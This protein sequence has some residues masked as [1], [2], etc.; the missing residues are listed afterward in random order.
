MM[1]EGPLDRVVVPGWVSHLEANWDEQRS[2]LRFST[3]NAH[4]LKGV[5]GDWRLF[6]V[7]T[8]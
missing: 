8:S 3:G 2:G 6:A 5:P 7:A 4:A 1:G